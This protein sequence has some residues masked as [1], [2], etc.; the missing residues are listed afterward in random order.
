[1]LGAFSAVRRAGLMQRAMYS[2]GYCTIYIFSSGYG[3]LYS[4]AFSLQ[5]KFGSPSRFGT[6]QDFILKLRFNFAASLK[7]IIMLRVQR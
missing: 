2:N 1:M 7:H 5:G 6:V 3:L 4:M